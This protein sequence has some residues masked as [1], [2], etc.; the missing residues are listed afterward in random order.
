[1]RSQ[2]RAR[3]NRTA[4]GLAVLFG[5]LA[6]LGAAHPVMAKGA[7]KAKTLRVIYTTRVD[8]QINS[9]AKGQGG[10]AKLAAFIKANRTDNTI[11]VDGGG[12]GNGLL[13]AAVYGEA[14]DPWG[15]MGTMGYD[16]ALQTNDNRFAS[17]SKQ[18]KTVKAQ[19]NQAPKIV[20]RSSASAALAKQT[21][22]IAVFNKNGIK[23]G[24]MALSSGENFWTTEQRVRQDLDRLKNNHCDV[25]IALSDLTDSQNKRIARL[26]HRINIIVDGRSGREIDDP[27]TAGKTAIVSAGKNGMQIGVMDYR[28]DTQE[29]KT[30]GMIPMSANV[31]ADQDT[32]DQV[33]QISAALTQKSDPSQVLATSQQDF[34]SKKTRTKKFADNDTGNLV[35]DAY[36]AQDDGAVGVVAESSLRDRLALGDVTVQNVV[37]LFSR[38]SGRLV[39]LTV[40]GETLRDFCEVDATMGYLSPERQLYFSG[41][42]YDYAP[43]RTPFNRVTQVRVQADGKW[44]AVRADRNYTVITDQGTLQTIQ[45]APMN[46][47]VKK[48]KIQS[49][50]GWQ[51]VVSAVSSQSKDGAADLSANYVVTRTAKKAVQIQSVSAYFKNP[52]RFGVLTD[53]VAI[54]VIALIVSVIIAGQMKKCNGLTRRGQ[55]GRKL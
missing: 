18:A 9:N 54:V 26:N 4:V 27:I 33:G 22:R 50:L 15:L 46:I 31:K 21:E 13:N 7:K 41:L 25:I 28:V 12:F 5:L 44:Q 24:V 43:S 52:S 39:K 53:C 36:A 42:A 2:I 14:G 11:V 1:M 40:S 48:Q 45:R 29:V 3:I 55:R 8:G 30:D 10:A 20:S 16:A 49:T 19:K 17:Y 32:A 37:G 23:V 38:S 47:A 35:S 34:T 51:A 6:L